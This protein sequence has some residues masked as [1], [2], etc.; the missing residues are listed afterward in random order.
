MS[1]YQFS[2]YLDEIPELE[3]MFS[4]GKSKQKDT[5]TTEDLIN[6]AKKK[7]IKTPKKY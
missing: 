4:G 6:M 3:K 5:T 7:G 2:S 1:L